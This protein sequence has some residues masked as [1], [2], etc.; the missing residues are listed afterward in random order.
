M[1]SD[2]QPLIKKLCFA[3][4]KDDQEMSVITKGFEHQKTNRLVFS[5]WRE[6]RNRQLKSNGEPCP[7]D[8]LEDLKP[9]KLNHWLSCFMAEV[10]NAKGEPYP[11]FR[12]YCQDRFVL[13]NSPITLKFMD[14]QNTIIIIVICTG[15]VM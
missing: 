5:D 7:L 8:L 6:E 1:D 10:R 14:K 9:E 2:F 4:P 3:C 15:H 12:T 11:P 13:E